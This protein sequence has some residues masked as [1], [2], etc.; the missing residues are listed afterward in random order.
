VELGLHELD[1]PRAVFGLVHAHQHRAGRAG[2]GGVQDVELGA[3]VVV[4]L[5]PYSR[6]H[7]CSKSDGSVCCTAA[8]R[9]LDTREAG[10]ENFFRRM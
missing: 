8:R 10:T 2:A 9:V 1:D 6:E 7:P 3:V 4:D 5:K